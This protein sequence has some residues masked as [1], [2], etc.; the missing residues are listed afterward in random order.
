MAASQKTL[1]SSKSSEKTE[2]PVMA[3]GSNLD[4]RSLTY[5]AF[6]KTK[7]LFQISSLLAGNHQPCPMYN[8]I[9]FFPYHVI[10]EK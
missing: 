5:F 6:Y 3:A 8:F 10:K 2:L 4:V 1:S 9:F 7:T